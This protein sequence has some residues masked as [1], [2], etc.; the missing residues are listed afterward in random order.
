MRSNRAHPRGANTQPRTWARTVARSKACRTRGPRLKCPGDAVLQHPEHSELTILL[1]SFSLV[2]H[3][4]GARTHSR[5]LARTPPCTRRPSSMSPAPVSQILRTRVTPPLPPSSWSRSV[6]RL[7]RT[8]LP[9]P[10]QILHRPSAELKT[11]AGR[12]SLL[13]VKCYGRQSSS[14]CDGALPRRSL[15][16][17][18]PS[19]CQHLP[20]SRRP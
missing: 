18:S 10:R 16:R 4:R 5:I 11:L 7:G 9:P 6:H 13:Q 20:T 3:P 15:H 14:S 17:P 2:A 12:G 8:L 1:S 19:N